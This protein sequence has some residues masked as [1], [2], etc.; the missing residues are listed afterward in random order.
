MPV[1]FRLTTT[2]F[3]SI[4]LLV[5]LGEH[6]CPNEPTFYPALSIY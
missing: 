3:R 2:V 4:I 6:A 1:R 5:H